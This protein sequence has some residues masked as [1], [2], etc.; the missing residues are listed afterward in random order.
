MMHIYHIFFVC[1]LIAL[2]IFFS[3]I[4][5]ILSTCEFASSLKRRQLTC[6]C[7]SC[8]HSCD[9]SGT[10]KSLGLSSSRWCCEDVC[11]SNSDYQLFEGLA[12]DPKLCCNL[13]LFSATFWMNVY[14]VVTVQ[15]H[16]S[17]AGLNSCTLSTFCD[18]MELQLHSS[19]VAL[20][21]QKAT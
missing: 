5:S 10:L 4:L 20:L 11:W 16:C 3:C 7:W 6:N 14:H 13:T 18:A 1:V 8:H 12:W 21:E 15:K 19:V 17:A 9:H 2:G